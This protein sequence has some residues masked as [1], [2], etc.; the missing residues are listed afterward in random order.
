MT[1]YRPLKKDKGP[2]IM[3]STII[4]DHD[5]HDMDGSSGKMKIPSLTRLVMSCARAG[6]G[7]RGDGHTTRSP[8]KPQFTVRTVI[9]PIPFSDAPI[10]EVPVPV[11]EIAPVAL[12]SA[13]PISEEFHATCPVKGS[14][15]PSLN[16]PVAVNC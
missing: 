2:R 15:L 10:V 5:D 7:M 12:I 4:I 1:D 6:A 8:M 3:P 9:L 11:V 13:T 16:V 14:V